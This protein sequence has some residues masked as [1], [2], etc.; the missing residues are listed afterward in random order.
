[1]DKFFET[2][3]SYV[4]E[5]QPIQDDSEGSS[6]RNQCAYY[7]ELL[8]SKPHIKRIVEIGFNSGISATAFLASR[9]DIEV[10]SID[11][12]S[13]DYIIKIKKVVDKY[14][15][16]RH[17][18]VCGDST[19]AVPM[20]RRFFEGFKPVDLFF[21]DGWHKEPVPR[22]DLQNALEWCGPD[23]L[24]IV[25]D[26]CPMHGSEGVVQAVADF[27]EQRKIDVIEHK[28]SADRGWMLCKKGPASS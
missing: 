15:P 24:I 7:Y 18:L 26:V 17:T 1:M 20:L 12:C 6:V 8:M 9:P 22:I 4:K 3:I 16:G 11:I 5:V 23:S 14:F 27:L 25:D 2:F 10:I 19:Q 21:I 13:H 28:M